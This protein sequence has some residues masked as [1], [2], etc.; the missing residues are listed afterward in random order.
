MIDV[1]IPVIF[2]K[3]NH[4]EAFFTKANRGIDTTENEYFGLNF[5]LTT[6]AD[7]HE[8]KRNYKALLQHLHL[9]NISLALAKQVHGNS[10]KLVNKGGIYPETDGFITK[11]R[12]IYLGIQVADCA[13]VLIVDPVHNILGAFHAG[14]RGAVNGIISEGLELMKKEGGSTK[15][16]Y[17]FLSPCISQKAFEV[18]EEVAQLF[19]GQYCDRNSYRKPHIDLAGYIKDQIMDFGVHPDNIEHVNECTYHNTDYFSYR[20]ERDSAGR[21]LAMIGLK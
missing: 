9:E 1:L 13:A 12:N 3:F 7:T 5:G 16:L 10:I 20:R 4:V 11:T 6:N 15:D 19:P 2:S 8:I 21:M 14:W 17:V 18:G